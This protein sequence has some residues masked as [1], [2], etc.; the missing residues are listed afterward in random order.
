MVMKKIFANW[1]LDIAKYVVTALVLS[2][3]L[4]LKEQ[5]WIYYAACLVFV[6]IVLFVAIILFKKDKNNT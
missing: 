3:A 6:V 4:G 5:G 2:T 1:L